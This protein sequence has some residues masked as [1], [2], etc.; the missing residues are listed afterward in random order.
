[1]A[2]LQSDR[3]ERDDF[4]KI[5]MKYNCLGKNCTSGTLSLKFIRFQNPYQLQNLKILLTAQ[6]HKIPPGQNFWNLILFCLKRQ[7][8]VDIIRTKINLR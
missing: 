1:M 7:G 2:K 6:V 3:Y 5:W 8:Y 4:H